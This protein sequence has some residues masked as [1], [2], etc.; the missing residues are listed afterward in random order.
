MKKLPLCRVL[1][2]KA[3]PFRPIR[4]KEKKNKLLRLGWFP[5]SQRLSAQHAAKPHQAI[6]L[7]RLIF[8]AV[9]ALAALGADEP[10][11]RGLAGYSADGARVEREWEMKFRALPSPDNM[12]E[13]MK[14]LS[15]RPHHVG[16]PYDQDNAQWILSKF[17]EWGLDA[18]IETFHVL[19]PTP[20]ERLVEL[21]EPT[22]FVA[23]LQ[24]PAFSVDPT[25]D[26]MDE[27]LP[28]YNAYSTDGDVTGPL[29]YVNYGVPEDYKQLER[30]GLSV[31]G[32][33]VIA[34]YGASW[35]GIK[36]KVAAEHGAVGCLIYS[37]PRDDGY[38]QGDV[39][40]QGPWRPLEGAQR[41]SVMDMTLYSG[42]P[43]TPGVG[44]TEEAKR[45]PVG[46]APTITKVPVMPLSYG[47][48]QPLLAALQGP[49][50]PDGWRGALPLPYHIGPGPAKVHLRVSFNWDIKPIYDV[51]ARVTGSQ[52][53]AEWIIRGNHHDAW[54]NGAQDPISGQMALLEEARGFADL[55]KEGWKPRRTIIYCAWDGEEEGLLGSTE[56][57]EQH[58]D[59]LQA[60]AAV[61]INTDSNGRGYLNAGGSHTLEQFINGVER[62]IEDPE[63]RLSVWKRNQLARIKKAAPDDLQEVRQRPDLRIGALG[64]GSDYTGFLQHL[65]IAALNLSYDGEDG[66]GIYHSVYDDFYWYTHFSDTQFV[67]GRALAQTVGTS[68]MRLA[69]AGLLPLDFTNFADTVRKYVEELRALLKKEQDETR[70]RNKQIEEGVFAAT[71]D[72]RQVS[73]PPKMEEVPPYLNFAPLDNAV[74]SLSQGAGRYAKALAKARENG[75][76]ALD[77]AALDSVDKRLIESERRLTTREGLPRRPWYRHQIYAPG[78]YTGYGVKTIPAVREAIEEKQWKEADEQIVVVA[79]VLND[80]AALIDSAAA[81]LDKAIAA[82]HQMPRP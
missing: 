56:W 53:P 35:R 42:D 36:P 41:G 16:S 52:Y 46:E 77:R 40:P 31:K 50:A 17:K 71:A 28:T 11:N 27:Q 26:Q 8:L 15:A 1:C 47:D 38:F 80:E 59:E 75:G 67:Y 69:D 32:A 4:R 21:V 44:A 76:S 29:V 34:R 43:L 81:E 20:K 39:F 10:Q 23:K 33:I 45:L 63:T 24:E 51:I 64:S 55:L 70:E 9:F 3:R 54:V 74:S 58:A 12:R 6:R 25:S 66:G 30:L 78:Y 60:N 19:F 61:Y 2:G 37:D 49:M 18:H 62:D 65:G 14:R 5:E 22:K 7:S 72:P 73:I 48:A 68:V 13:Y 79:K 82:A 57:A